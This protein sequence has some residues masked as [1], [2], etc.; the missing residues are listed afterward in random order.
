MEA[1]TP[2]YPTRLSD[3]RWAILAIYFA[4]DSQLG[5]P[6]KTHLRA[7]VE[8]IPSSRRKLQF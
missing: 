2:A 8:A 1:I 3:A 7:V 5:R 4:A 6:R